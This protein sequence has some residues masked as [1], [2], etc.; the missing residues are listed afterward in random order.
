MISIHAL[1]EEGDRSCRSSGKRIYHFY[2][3]PPR[4]GRLSGGAYTTHRL[5]FYPRPPR[6]GR[7]KEERLRAGLSQI[8]IHALREEGDQTPHSTTS[9][10]SY[11]YP[12]PP[13]GGRHL[14]T[15]AGKSLGEFLST[16]SARRATSTVARMLAIGGNFYPRPPRGGRPMLPQHGK[17]H[18]PISIH[19]LREEGDKNCSSCWN[20][21]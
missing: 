1:R 7:L 13:R 8:S 5:N 14:I 2:P 18:Q 21:L 20:R 6:G 4:G 16:P 3:R 19:A 17:R 15:Y 9:A 12:R 10:G 11:F